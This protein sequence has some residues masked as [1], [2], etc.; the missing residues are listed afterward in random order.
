[1]NCCDRHLHAGSSVWKV[2]V[3]T[4]R[5]TTPD[6][7]TCGGLACQCDGRTVRWHRDEPLLF[8]MTRNPREDDPL[9]VTDPRYR[10]FVSKTG[11][12]LKEHLDTL[13]KNVESQTSFWNVLWKPH[14]QPCC[15][16]PYCSCTDPKYPSS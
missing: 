6:S 10:P 4:P 13:D 5:W 14:L 15:N 16:F 7:D 12:G 3:A 8:D 2:R 1:M 9:D 11:Q